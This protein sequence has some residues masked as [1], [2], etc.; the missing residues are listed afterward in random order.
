MSNLAQRLSIL[1]WSIA[2]FVLTGCVVGG[3][4]SSAPSDVERGRAIVSANCAQCHA[5]GRDDSSPY[6]RAPPMRTLHL[7]YQVE[8]LA[9]ALAEGITVGHTGEKQMPEVSLSPEEIDDLI[10]YLKSFKQS[11]DR[12]AQ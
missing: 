10:A 4:N 7:K 11:G 3:F 9:E 2:P 12:E 1:T 6:E 8:N 5:I